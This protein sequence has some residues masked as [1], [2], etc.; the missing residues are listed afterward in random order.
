VDDTVEQVVQGEHG[1]EELRLVSGGAVR[2]DLFVDCSGFASL[3]LEKTLGVPFV[4]F[5]RTLFNDRAVV[6]GWPRTDEPIKPY[7]TCETMNSGWCWQIEHE[8]LV[9]RGYV[10]SSDFISDEEAEAEFRAKN[11]KVTKTRV[12]RFRSGRF[13]RTWVKNVVAIGNSSGFVEPLEATGLG[14]ICTQA[15]ALVEMLIEGDMQMNPSLVKHYEARMIKQWDQIVNFLAVHYRY[16]T[17]LDT[18]YWRACQNDAELGWAEEIVDYYRAVGPSV[19][20]RET[21]LDYNDQFGMEGYLS[22]LVGQC[23]PYRNPYQPSDQERTNWSRIQQAVRNKVA[24]AYTVR[25]ALDFVRSEYWQWPPTMYCR[26]LGRGST[27]GTS[28]ER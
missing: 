12:V 28:V 4:S 23:V 3:L 24:S 6:G 15:Q 19:I 22:M 1:V 13:E 18:P 8:F 5:R 16:N 21:L 2:A 9:N 11:P 27:A 14:Y 7:T 10:Y 20:A 17:R 26:P 25:E